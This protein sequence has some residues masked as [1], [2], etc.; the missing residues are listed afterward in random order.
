MHAFI[1]RITT[2]RFNVVSRRT[3]GNVLF[4]VITY[5]YQV[6]LEMRQTPIRGRRLMAAKVSDQVQR[7]EGW[8]RSMT[9]S[10]L[11]VSD[12]LFSLSTTNVCTVMC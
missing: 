2:T 10:S 4:I 7:R 8:R 6:G 9:T 3:F 5:V 12:T 11:T 1:I